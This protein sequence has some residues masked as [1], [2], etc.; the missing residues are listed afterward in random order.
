MKD[1][2]DVAVP[3]Q[4]GITDFD[5]V[6]ITGGLAEGDQVLLLP[7]ASLVDLYARRDGRTVDDLKASDIELTEDGVKQTIESFEHVIVRPPV[8]QELRAEP[9]SVE[10]A[11]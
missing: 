3:V 1:G 11:S 4:T 7:T 6:E 2:H 10:N 5:R 8:S 9:N